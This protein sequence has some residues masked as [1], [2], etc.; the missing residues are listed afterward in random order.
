VSAAIESTTNHVRN[1]KPAS[2][3]VDPHRLTIMEEDNNCKKYGCCCNRIH[4]TAPSSMSAS[5]IIDDECTTSTEVTG[6]LLKRCGKKLHKTWLRRKVR[7][8]DDTFFIWH[9]DVSLHMRGRRRICNPG[10]PTSDAH[11]YGYV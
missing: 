7:L 11:Q 5:M 4:N 2:E 1:R 8:S 6:H 10:N 9:S 3:L